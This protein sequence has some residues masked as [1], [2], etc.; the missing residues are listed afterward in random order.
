MTGHRGLILPIKAGIG[1]GRR[2]GNRRVLFSMSR[3]GSFLISSMISE[4]GL[5]QCWVNSPAN[6]SSWK[7]SHI[8]VQTVLA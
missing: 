6:S 7:T 4:C 2:M 1:G 8:A 5:T 3:L